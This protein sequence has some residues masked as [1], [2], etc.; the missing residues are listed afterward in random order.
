MENYIKNRLRVIVDLPPLLKAYCRY[1][2]KTPPKQEPIVVKRNNLIGNALNG[3]VEKSTT[4]R[5]Y[6]TLSILFTFLFRKLNSTA[7]R[8]IQ[9]TSD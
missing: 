8:L 9:I 2:F 3:L 5:E 6:E 1:V 7:I 4:G